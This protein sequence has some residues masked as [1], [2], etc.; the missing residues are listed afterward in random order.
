VCNCEERDRG[1]QGQAAVACDCACPVIPPSQPTLR[2]YGLAVTRPLDPAVAPLPLFPP[3][4][5]V[6]DACGAGAGTG[7]GAGAGV[8][9]A[10]GA[11]A[12]AAAPVPPVKA[13]APTAANAATTSLESTMTAITRPTGMSAVP[14]ATSTLAKYPESWHSKSTVALSVATSAMTSPGFRASPSF[15][16]HFTNVPAVMVGDSAGMAILV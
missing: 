8:G 5:C 9:A 4:A 11:A 14:S 13:S 7:A 12:A 1:E 3:A 6:E 10:A 16:C 15:L 2:A